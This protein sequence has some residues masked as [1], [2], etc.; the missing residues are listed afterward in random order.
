LLLRP[1][2]G[3]RLRIHLLRRRHRQLHRR[4]PKRQ[5]SQSLRSRRRLRPLQEF[6]RAP[7]CPILWDCHR[8]VR[9]QPRRRHPLRLRNRQR[10]T[11]LQR[12]K[13]Q[14]SI[15]RLELLLG[16]NRSLR[17]SWTRRETS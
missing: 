4:L 2:R 9:R 5:L 12:Y 7:Q 10:Q 8:Q 17:F 3:R 1:R 15:T 14:R 13:A 16:K 6:R 11:P